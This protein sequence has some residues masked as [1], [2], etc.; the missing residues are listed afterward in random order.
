[1]IWNNNKLESTILRWEKNKEY[2]NENVQKNN[3]ILL[4]HNLIKT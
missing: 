4:L 2:Q 1:M 3:G